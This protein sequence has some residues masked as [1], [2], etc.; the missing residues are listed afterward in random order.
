MTEDQISLTVSLHTQ[1][2]GIVPASADATVYVDHAHYTGDVGMVGLMIDDESEDT[3][4]LALLAPEH[5][6]LLA[7]RLSRAAELALERDK[8]LPYV[9]SGTQR[10]ASR[11]GEADVELALCPPDAL[12]H[13]AEH[14]DHDPRKMH[15]D[16]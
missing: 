4:Q 14:C 8:E 12:C 11:R 13:D 1:L 5:A 6:L 3:H 9:E 7:N 15:I 2:V 16:H 10:W